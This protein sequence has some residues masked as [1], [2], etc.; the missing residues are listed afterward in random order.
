MILASITFLE[1]SGGVRF[2]RPEGP[3]YR[4]IA[5]VVRPSDQSNG[6][7]SED[8]SRLRPDGT[9]YEQ[10]TV[11]GQPAIQWELPDA[12]GMIT[13]FTHASWEYLVM[14]HEGSIHD[15]VPATRYSESSIGPYM[16]TSCGHSW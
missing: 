4:A 15:P 7:E 6:E 1:M 8:I 16:N 3:A 14:L 9:H 5:V 10:L 11:G 12:T 2:V 13:S